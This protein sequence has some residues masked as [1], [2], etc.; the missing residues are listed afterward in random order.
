LVGDQKQAI[1]EGVQVVGVQVQQHAGA[2]T[3][4]AALAQRVLAGGQEL[5]AFGGAPGGSP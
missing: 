2:V 1:A 5:V 4:A 3:L